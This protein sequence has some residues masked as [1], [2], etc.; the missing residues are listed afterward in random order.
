MEK[1]KSLA[2]VQN[3]VPAISETIR[4]IARAEGLPPTGITILG[5]RP[6]V[7]ASGL[8]YKLRK[9]A[10]DENLVL[11]KVEVRPIGEEVSVNAEGRKDPELTTFGYKGV[12]EFFDRTGF[13]EALKAVQNPTV[14][15]L[16]ILREQF[17]YHFEDEGWA[18][19]LTCP[20]IAYEYSGERGRK[21]R[22]RVLLENVRMMASRRASNRAKRLAVGCGLTSLEEVGYTEEGTSSREVGEE[23]PEEAP[24]ETEESPSEEEGKIR[25]E[26]EGGEAVYMSEEEYD[27][28]MEWV[29]KIDQLRHPVHARNWLAKHQKELEE[30]PEPVKVVLRQ[31]YKRK[32]RQ[33]AKEAGYDE[34]A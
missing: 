9:K 14:E 33:L 6:Y 32:L 3:Q 15:V 34:E 29:A 27:L 20:A 12:V 5:G 30:L 2:S 13:L 8:D 24:S 25:V 21:V 31:E 19:A 17:T 1:R 18:S 22:G 7:N 11:S 16:K 28:T 4:E 10:E 23:V 26:L